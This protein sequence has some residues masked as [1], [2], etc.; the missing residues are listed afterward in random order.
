MRAPCIIPKEN[1]GVAEFGRIWFGKKLCP[2]TKVCPKME[3]VAIR[4]EY[5]LRKCHP[6]KL[7]HGIRC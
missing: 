6:G 1:G 7:L 3:C 4:G 5:L 2:Q